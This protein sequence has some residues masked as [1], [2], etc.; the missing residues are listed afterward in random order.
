MRFVVSRLPGETSSN[1]D[2]RQ[3]HLNEVVR[4]EFSPERKNHTSEEKLFADLIKR[5][6]RRVMADITECEAIQIPV[7]L[8][9]LSFVRELI[10]H[11][12]NHELIPGSE[13]L[14]SSANPL[15]GCYTVAD[16]D[17]CLAETRKTHRA[18]AFINS[19]DEEFQTI[20]RKLDL[21]AGLFAQ[22]PAL[23]AVLDENIASESEVQS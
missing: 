17:F 4:A 14:H 6:A 1:H 10:A 12:K 11:A 15:G 18:P 23:N 5:E 9:R 13:T 7:H 2:W 3:R 8:A 16:F 21:L 20:N 22:S 19:R